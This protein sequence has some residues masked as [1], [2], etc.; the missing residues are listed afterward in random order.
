MNA[1]TIILL[2]VVGVPLAIFCVACVVKT[3][4]E[5]LGKDQKD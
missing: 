1:V 3:L 5:M 2:A 4:A